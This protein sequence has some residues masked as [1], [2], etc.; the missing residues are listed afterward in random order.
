MELWKDYGITSYNLASDASTFPVDYW[1]LKQAFNY[2]VPSVV[3]LDVYD[4][5]PNAII[6]RWEHVHD[7]IGAFPISLDK[8]RM[9]RDLGRNPEWVDGM[10]G[11]TSIRW[12]LILKMA[13]YH[14]RWDKLGTTDFDTYEM[15][16]K[17]SE[18][19]KGAKALTD[20]ESRVEKVY[21]EVIEGKYDETSKEYLEMII[22]LC[23]Q[24]GCQVLLINTGYDCKEEAKLFA[25]SV[26]DI[27][28]QYGLNY[29][30]FTRMNLIDFDCDLQTTGNNTHVNAS[31][32]YKFT[33]YIGDVLV[34]EYNVENH[35]NDVLCEKWHEDYNRYV[36][37]MEDSLRELSSFDQY[38]ELL[39]GM[40]YDV[41]IDIYD[42]N[43]IH[44]GFNT[45]MLR[46]LGVDINQIN[47][48]IEIKRLTS[49]EIIYDNA[50]ELD[51][52][53]R[54]KVV[55]FDPKSQRVVDEKTF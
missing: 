12:D 38:I 40:D 8:I 52:G 42:E 13:E 26:P 48:G 31:G 9:V 54:A 4:C 21:P 28:K 41:T 1:V 24:Y 47:E 22:D 6:Y 7:S 27:A 19:R 45:Q 44:E 17:Q 50:V 3:V 15:I 14:E 51:G 49:R 36:S 46:N 37:Y 18:I 2:H 39:Y 20:I 55:V 35:K 53:C 25:D 29:Y 30:D 16:Q 34:R 33:K 23:K 10:G 5:A 32:G 11:P 43:F